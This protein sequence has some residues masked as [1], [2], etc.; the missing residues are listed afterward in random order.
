MQTSS[1]T[2]LARPF[3]TECFRTEP[4]P[5]D[6]DAVEAL[7]RATGAFRADEVDCARELLEEAL[8]DGQE[9]SGYYF[10]FADGVDAAGNWRLDGYA[11]F[12]PIPMTL[13]RYEL[14]WIAVHPEARGT[15]IGKR[16]ARQTEAAV[17]AEGGTHIFAVTSTKSD[18]WAA[19][20]FYEAQGYVKH[21]DVPD[22]HAD[23]DGLAMY[24]KRL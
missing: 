16:L 14:Y 13:G 23:G 6:V 19:R 1:S 21:A 15:G 18:Y 24:G 8:R 20:A 9:A 11:C 10:L 22:Y 17:R 12:G 2:S 4:R 5:E 3:V 7:T